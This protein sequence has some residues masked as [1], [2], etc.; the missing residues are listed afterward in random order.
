MSDAFVGGQEKKKITSDLP[1]EADETR[2]PPKRKRVQKTT[3]FPCLDRS[4]F[5]VISHQDDGSKC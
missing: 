1:L 4:I 2:I 5:G 3:F